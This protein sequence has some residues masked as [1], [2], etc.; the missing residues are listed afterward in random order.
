MRTRRGGS[1]AKVLKC[2]PFGADGTGKE[3]PAGRNRGQ[4]PRGLD[5]HA[6]F[7]NISRGIAQHQSQI[8]VAL[9]VLVLALSNPGRGATPSPAPQKT[10]P[11]PRTL[12]TRRRWVLSATLH[13]SFRLPN[14]ICHGEQPQWPLRL[15]S[16]AGALMGSVSG[17]VVIPGNSKSSALVR[18]LADVSG[19]I[20]KKLLV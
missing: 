11:W 2:P 20:V 15:N 18:R 10:V 9:G 5:K 12:P 4:I 13:P 6:M 19:N 14:V 7:R 3:G 8:L 1:T 17:K 16:L